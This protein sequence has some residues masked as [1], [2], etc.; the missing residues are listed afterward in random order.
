MPARA[1][2]AVAR[3]VNAG[4][5]YDRPYHSS[6]IP[7][8]RGKIVNPVAGPSEDGRLGGASPTLAWVKL[9]HRPLQLMDLSREC[10]I[11][12]ESASNCERPI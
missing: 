10:P 6:P 4:V 1:R 12:V 2:Y 11:T 8:V 5:P 7:A 3:H 9:L